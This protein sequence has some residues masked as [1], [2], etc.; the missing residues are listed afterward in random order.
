MSFLALNIVKILLRSTMLSRDYLSSE[1]TMT[2][3]L[4]TNNNPKGAQLSQQFGPGEEL[5]VKG[6][7]LSCVG[8]LSHLRYSETYYY[9]A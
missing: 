2:L 1:F 3:V 8:F 4:S 7:G 5:Q 9:L 6:R